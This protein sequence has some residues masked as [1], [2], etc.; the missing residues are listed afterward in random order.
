MARAA[1]KP[2]KEV[3]MEEAPWLRRTG[4][5]QTCGVEPF[6]LEVCQRQV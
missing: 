2:K 1:A 4:R 5:I 3:S 6:L